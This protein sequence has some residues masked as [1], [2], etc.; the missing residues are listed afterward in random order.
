[1][2]RAV[3]RAT[4][5]ISG[6]IFAAYIIAF[7]RGLTAGSASQRWNEALP[8][9]HDGRSPLTT[10]AI[11]AH[12]V[13]GGVLPLLGPIQLIGG[14]RHAVPWLHRWLRRIYVVSAGRTS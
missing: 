2:E 7:F 1:L 3:A 14:V 13:A 6:A 4:C 5:W 12:F 10:I 8:D 9:L 11:G